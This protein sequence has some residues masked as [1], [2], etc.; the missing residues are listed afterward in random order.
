[1]VLENLA[2][3]SGQ[4]AF[5]RQPKPPSRF[6]QPKSQV[7]TRPSRGCS[8]GTPGSPRFPFKGSFKGDIDIIGIDIDVDMDIGLDALG[9]LGR[10]A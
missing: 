6:W 10:S 4:G 5:G 7:A 2:D 8:L 3:S 1:M 9:G